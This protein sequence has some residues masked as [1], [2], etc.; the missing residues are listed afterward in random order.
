VSGFLASAD[1]LATIDCFRKM[2]IAIQTDD[3]NH[4]IVK[5]KG[6]RGLEKPGQRLYVGNSGTTIRL[7]SGI[8]AG[9]DFISEISGDES[10][11]RRPMGRIAKPLRLMGG[12]I[13]GR[14]ERDKPGELFPPLK[15][16]GGKLNGI[17]YELPVAS[18]QVKSAILLAGLYANGETTVIEKNYSRDHT[19]RM[20]EHFGAPIAKQ[21][22]TVRLTP[23]KE[24]SANEVDVPGDISSAAFFMAAATLIP[25]SEVRIRNV[26]LNPTRTGILDILHRMGGA[27]EVENEVIG[28]G[29]PRGDIVVRSAQLRGI[30][31]DGA[32]IP[33]I[34]DEIP[35]IAV[36]ASQAEGFT[37]IRDARELRVKES[38]RIKTIAAEL[39]K[40]GVTIEELED[41]LRILGPA[42]LK[43]GAIE[44]RGDHRI[45]MAMAIAGLVA[46]GPT[47]INDADCVET[48]F[49]GFIDRLQPFI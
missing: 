40:F 41:G 48:S 12:E 2:G 37:E 33:R 8:L 18:A 15:I 29:E 32:I 31:I 36:L 3:S 45:A 13:Q 42:K 1:C 20:L 11:Q 25:G 22:E 49:P 5:G 27:V 34:I 24:L 23:A 16:T 43:G 35:I 39:G 10:I 46:T 21:G 47:V 26:G 17:S 19:E 6:L 38:D 7:L 14:K 28:S 44:S 30:K 4:V 9:Q